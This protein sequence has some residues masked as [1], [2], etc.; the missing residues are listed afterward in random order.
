MKVKFNTILIV[1]CLVVYGAGAQDR[2]GIGTDAPD[3]LLDIEDSS[4]VVMRIQSTT[5]GIAMRSGLML[6]RAGAGSNRD[7]QFLNLNGDFRIM[8]SV[9]DFETSDQVLGID[10]SGF[11]G[12]G[13]TNAVTRLQVI[14]TEEADNST[15]GY[16]VIGDKTGQNLVFDQNEII[17]R[18]NGTAAPLIFQSTGGDIHLQNGGGNTYMSPSSGYVLAG[19]A[20]G[21]A[22]FNMGSND[23]FQLQ[24]ISN[25]GG[26]NEWFIGASESTWAA[27]DNQLLF[28]PGSLSNSAGFRLATTEDN[29]GNMAPVV[30]R[31]SASQT[32][33]VDGN[34]IDTKSGALY[35]NNNTQH[36]T[37][38]NTVGGEVGIGTSS[39]NADLHI[40]A[41]PGGYAL[42]LEKAGNV[43]NIQPFTNT[44]NLGF[45]HDG[46][47]VAH[48]D[49]ASGAWVALSDA[50]YKTDIRDIESMLPLLRQLELKAYSFKY[51][52]TQAPQLGFI[53]QEVREV[54]PEVVSE[55]E[56]GNLSMSYSQFSVVAIKAL[57]EQDRQIADL[58]ADLVEI[59][60]QLEATVKEPTEKGD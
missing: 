31:S 39:P 28:S 43:W 8:T 46:T 17:A 47:L 30:I 56:E 27:G 50:N 14:G 2:M 5:G 52:S 35:I 13:I 57:Q 10:E 21:D 37:Y 26:L 55:D 49:D 48:I 20:T 51:D 36:D 54:L 18:N 53:A 19:N 59:I 33:L 42:A 41:A 3:R 12:L 32:L 23:I 4:P 22:K 58:E 44:D 29:D 24:L 11:V 7:Y 1:F 25:D 6:T 60:A 9:D 40:K 15:D 38:F 34:E 45:I 16:M